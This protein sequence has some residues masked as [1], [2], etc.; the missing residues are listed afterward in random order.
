[1]AYPLLMQIKKKI[2]NIQEKQREKFG[3]ELINT[4]IYLLKK[5]NPF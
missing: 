5:I 1:M 3:T 2:I 4:S